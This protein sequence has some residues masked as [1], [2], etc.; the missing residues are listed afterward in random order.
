MAV[1]GERKDIMTRVRKPKEK[2][3]SSKGTNASRA[4]WA[5]QGSGGWWGG[6]NWRGQTWVGRIGPQEV[7]RWKLIFEF[8]LNSNFNIV[9]FLQGDLEGVWTWEFFL[10]SFGLLKELYKI[11]YAIP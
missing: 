2:M 6:A 8:Q 3:Y 10:N 11:Q 7:F 4:G 1:T 9:E 5:M